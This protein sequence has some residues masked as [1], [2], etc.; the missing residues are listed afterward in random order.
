L[1]VDGVFNVGT[2]LRLLRFGRSSCLTS[3]V[4][5]KDGRDFDSFSF[6]SEQL[7]RNSSMVCNGVDHVAFP[8]PAAPSSFDPRLLVRDHDFGLGHNFVSSLCFLIS[9][10]SDRLLLPWSDSDG[11]LDL[12]LEAI[13]SSEGIL[14]IELKDF[15][16]LIASLL[17]AL[18]SSGK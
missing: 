13:R 4:E 7:L 9:M 2:L 15:D 11:G 10:L 16:F 14:S 1:I 17:A 5:N 8:S 12:L 6:F 3:D 18:V